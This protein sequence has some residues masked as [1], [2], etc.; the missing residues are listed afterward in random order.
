MQKNLGKLSSSITREHK[1]SV[2]RDWLGWF[3]ILFW[4]YVMINDYFS[5]TNYSHTDIIW[6]VLAFMLVFSVSILLLGYRFG[7]DPDGIGRIAL[8]T[9]PIAIVLTATFSLFPAPLHSIAF[10][11][12]PFFIAPALIRSVYGVVKNARPGYTMTTYMLG[13]ASA[14][15]LMHMVFL[16]KDYYLDVLMREPPNKLLFFVCAVFLVPAWVAARRKFSDSTPLSQRNSS[17]QSIE[18]VGISKSLILGIIAAI[19]I[20]AWLRQMCDYTNN[21]IEQYDDIL[22]I[23]LYEVMPFIT[24]VMLGVIADKKLEKPVITIAFALYLIAI[25]IAMLVPEPGIDRNPGVIP[26][27]FMNRF[28]NLT[29]EYIAYTIPVYFMLFTKRP[30]FAASAGLVA[31]LFC[32]TGSWTIRHALMDT[33]GSAGLP[34]FISSAIAAVVFLLVINA[35]FDRHKEKTLAAALYSAL[36]SSRISSPQDDTEETRQQNMLDTGLTQKEIEITRLLIDGET[37]RNVARKLHLTS[38][39]LSQFEQAIKR[40]ILPGDDPDINIS[41]VVKEYKLTKR[42]TDIFKY[43]CNRASTAEISTELVIAE[44]TVRSHIS[45]LVMKLGLENRSDIPKW[46]EMR[47]H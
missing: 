24:Y 26:L 18:A 6:S 4:M 25:M 42:E 32:R 34:L 27:L 45:R 43:L 19:V 23:P 2:L 16:I 13:V 17:E 40:K 1:P 10:A 22:Y 15:V 8:Y 46:F 30:L 47:K 9:T 37:R 29:V 41:A 35:I 36:F 14:Y 7:S 20:L 44:E 21:S 5:Y 3:G 12:S 28:V 38:S 39:E 31:Y 33:F 11:I